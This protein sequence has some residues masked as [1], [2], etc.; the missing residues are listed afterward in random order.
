VLLRDVVDQLHDDDRLADAR[1][2]EESDLAAA[3]VRCEEIN[4]FDARLECFDFDCL[5]GEQGGGS[6]DRVVLLGFDGTGL[7][8]GLADDVDDAAECLRSDGH[9]N[10]VAGI[11]NVHVADQTFGRVHGDAA[12]RLLSQVLR[13]FEDQVPRQIVDCRVGDLECVVD[14]WNRAVLEFDV[15]D[16]SD[17]LGNLAGAHFLSPPR[18]SGAPRTSATPSGLPHPRRFPS[19]LS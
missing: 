6:V 3:L 9:L 14:G 1:A 17:D 5:V 13:D 10:A 8:H 12:N 18:A 11:L 2:A 4:D 19:A 16:G 15:D 7:V